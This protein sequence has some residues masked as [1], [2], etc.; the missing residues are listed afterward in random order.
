VARLSQNIKHIAEQQLA[1]ANTATNATYVYQV[2]VQLAKQ[3]ASVQE[4]PI[5]SKF[6]I[7]L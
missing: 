2:L 6:D 5:T 1:T 4:H 3:N 7:I